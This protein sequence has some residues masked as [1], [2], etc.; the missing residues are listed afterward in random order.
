[1]PICGAELLGWGVNFCAAESAVL[2]AVPRSA[3]ENWG[4]LGAHPTEWA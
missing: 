2:A 1:M 4:S 3:R